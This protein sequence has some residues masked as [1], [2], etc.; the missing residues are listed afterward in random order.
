MELAEETEQAARSYAAYLKQLMAYASPYGMIPA[1]IQFLS[2]TE[3]EESFTLLH[4]FADP[5]KQKASMEKQIRAGVSVGKD[6]YVRQFPV[7]FS[8]RGNNAVLLSQGMAARILGDALADPELTA[9]ADRQ[10]YFVCGLN[11]F[12]QSLIY[13]EGHAYAKQYAAQPGQIIGQIPVGMETYEDADEP[14]Y[15]EANNATYKEIWTS[16]AARFL[17]CL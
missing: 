13:G 11:P 7:W 3:D 16:P 6:A 4:L 17:G 12:A 1:G 14:F 10:R 5:K 9:I 2:E 8:F 15:P